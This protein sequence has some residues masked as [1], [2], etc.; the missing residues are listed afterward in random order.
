MKYK[1]SLYYHARTYFPHCSA[2]CVLIALAV[3]N[4][5]LLYDF[6]LI[7]KVRHTFQAKKFQVS[8]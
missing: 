5:P 4:A 8:K 6:T 3:C 2:M 1:D 7:Y